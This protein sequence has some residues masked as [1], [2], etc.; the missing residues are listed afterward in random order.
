MDE[1]DALAQVQEYL[2]R[3]SEVFGQAEAELKREQYEH[4][5]T[6]FS[7]ALVDFERG[8]DMLAALESASL[9]K[10][11]IQLRDTL[12]AQLDTHRKQSKNYLQ[13]LEDQH[14]MN[15][16]L[17]ERGP[18]FISNTSSPWN[19][20]PRVMTVT[21]RA[22][23]SSDSRT[24][25]PTS[26]HL[27][28]PTWFSSTL[29][30]I[31]WSFLCTANLS[32]SAVNG[33]IRSWMNSLLCVYNLAFTSS[34]A[35]SEFCSAMFVGYRGHTF[36][37][38]RAIEGESVEN[39]AV[40]VVLSADLSPPL[41]KQFETIL[42]NQTTFCKKTPDAD[43]DEILE[44]STSA[45]EREEALAEAEA[46]ADGWENTV[47]RWLISGAHTVADVIRTAAHIGGAMIRSG[48]ESIRA[49]LTHSDG[50]LHIDP[51][52][53]A[54]V[55]TLK[56]A[57]A[58]TYR[59]TAYTV[60]KVFWLAERSAKAVSPYVLRF[61]GTGSGKG[62]GLTGKVVHVAK[63]GGVGALT[64]LAGLE[65]A[66]LVLTKELADESTSTVRHR[67]GDEAAEL[68]R[69]SLETVSNSAKAYTT[70][71]RLGR[72]ALTRH[73]VKKT[74]AE[75]LREHEG[76]MKQSASNP[77]PTQEQRHMASLL[78]PP[79]PRSPYQA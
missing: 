58:T 71:R 3:G 12:Q 56:G 34:P 10:A 19:P 46:P 26:C 27:R 32:S 21:K 7:K 68:A 45:V 24:R 22:S 47:S 43:D 11:Q 9:D 33:F 48:G 16:N 77:G 31:S 28:A 2:R 35:A 49:R 41:I 29:R 40:G 17:T 62:N 66:A 5:H 69:D 63:S 67:Y 52:V 51:R 23:S 18:W 73:A 64:I 65:D 30:A 44:L 72:K 76:T 42:E 57:T 36:H 39:S 8:C 60:D 78:P 4:A 61:V 59:V 55:A 53:Q 54:S 15:T 70:F 14:S 13:E 79:P 37:K 75:V 25:K 6:M 1:I 50:N 74:A 38:Q 20:V